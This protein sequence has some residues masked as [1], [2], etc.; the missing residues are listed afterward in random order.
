MLARAGARGTVPRRPALRGRMEQS[1]ETNLRG[2]VQVNARGVVGWV[3]DPDSRGQAIEIRL[4]LD[5]AVVR[6]GRAALPRPDVD[7]TLGIE[8]AM[9]FRLPSPALS[10]QDLVRAEF[11]A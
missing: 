5:G 2:N 3:F 11:Q 8:G 7:E 10:P 4:M 1:R 9:G 6:K